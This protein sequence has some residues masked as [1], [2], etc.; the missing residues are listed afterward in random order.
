MN[1]LPRCVLLLMVSAPVLASVPNLSPQEREN[2]R[3]RLEGLYNEVDLLVQNQKVDQ[4]DV[5]RQEREMAALKVYERIPLRADA[6]GL[7]RS[8]G[9]S[10][11]SYGIRIEAV[12][13]RRS[14]RPAPAA[15]P[16]SVY[17]DARFRLS[18]D[19]LVEEIPFR[20]VFSGD[21][22]RA[23]DWVRAWPADQMRLAEPVAGYDNFA[24]EPAGRG[25]WAVEARA[26]RFRA[27]RFPRLRPRDPAALLPAWARR[28]PGDFARAEPVLWSFVTRAR[29]RIPL[30]PSLYAGRSR[31][32][33]NDARMS[34][35]LAKA[36]PPHIRA[37]NDQAH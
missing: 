13:L 26:F 7:K 8:L 24:V 27:T 3:Y 33:L 2:L 11:K 10:A 31:F 34:F 36:M 16:S 9:E 29:R 18:Q 1:W 23:R 37:Q 14:R 35:F 19:Q 4:S 22:A 21:R 32:L 15:V 17:S 25:R 20:V 5:R 28:R 30:T 6:P 12:Q